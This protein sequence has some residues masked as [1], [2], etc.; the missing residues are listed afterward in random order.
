MPE[1]PP[2][3][4]LQCALLARGAVMAAR[5]GLGSTPIMVVELA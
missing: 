2:E 4:R 3:C 5:L 1:L